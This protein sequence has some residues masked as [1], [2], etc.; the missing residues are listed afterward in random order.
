MGLVLIL[1]LM[2]RNYI[3]GVLRNELAARNETLPHPFTRKEETSLTPEMAFEH[4]GGLMGQI[5]TLG[6]HRRRMPV[7]PSAVALRIL[8]L[9]DLNAEVFNPPQGLRWK[10][11]SSPGGTSEM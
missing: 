1:A 6:E 9:F 4:F 10:W 2:V 8:A 11:R 7:Q 5:V 3:Q